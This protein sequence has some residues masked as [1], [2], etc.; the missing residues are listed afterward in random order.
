MATRLT[1]MVTTSAAWV[2][3]FPSKPIRFV[4]PYMAGGS[5]DLVARSVGAQMASE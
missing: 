3:S 1:F 5:T 2:L 4:V